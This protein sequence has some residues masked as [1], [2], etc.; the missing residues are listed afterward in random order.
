MKIKITCILLLAVVATLSSCKSA[1]DITMFQDL[2][3]QTFEQK[4]MSV[5]P[6]EYRIKISDNLYVS[7]LTLDPEV[8]IIYNPSSAGSGASSGT[9]QAFGSEIGQLIN[10][11]RVATDSTINLPI[12]GKLNVV[13]LKLE[14]AEKKLKIK[15][16]EYLQD[17]TVQIKLLNFKV[18]VLGE[19]NVP[20]LVYNYEGSM[21]I[22]E[23][24]GNASGITTFADLKNIVVS[25]Q[26][27]NLTNSYKIDLTRDDI[28]NSAVFYLQPNDLIYVPPTNMVMRDESRS[29]YSLFLGTITSVLL[30]ITLIF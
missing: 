19:V 1:K 21:N 29:N 30:I 6:P 4:P 10:G 20:G 17:P 2:K 23:A 27:G 24:I 26:I 9:D 15:A 5:K 8:N 7:I 16:E 13:G 28:Y 14:E 22:Y 12:L 18:N 25:R 3:K 11:Y